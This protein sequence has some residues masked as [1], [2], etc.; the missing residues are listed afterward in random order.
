MVVPCVVVESPSHF[1]D[2]HRA[3]VAPINLHFVQLVIRDVA[4]HVVPESNRQPITRLSVDHAITSRSAQ[5]WLKLQGATPTM[6][7][8]A[9]PPSRPVS[10]K[11]LLGRPLSTATVIIR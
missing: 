7:R 5:H 4:G 6:A 11:P 3:A 2:R 9:G 8:E 10:F 1:L